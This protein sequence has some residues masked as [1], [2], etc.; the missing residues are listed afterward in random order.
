[1]KTSRQRGSDGDVNVVVCEETS[2][3]AAE[4]NRNHLSQSL[5]PPPLPP[6]E[7]LLSMS[8]MM[9]AWWSGQWWVAVCSLCCP[10]AD[11]QTTSSERQSSTKKPKKPPTCW[12]GMPLRVEALPTRAAGSLRWMR[13]TLPTQCPLP[14][15]LYHCLH[16]R[17][18]KPYSRRQHAAGL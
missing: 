2:L 4:L 6:F 5:V 14:L 12:R 10:T 3:H 18:A 17:Q 9:A 16:A 15:W 1:M 11:Q 13:H 8:S 7:P